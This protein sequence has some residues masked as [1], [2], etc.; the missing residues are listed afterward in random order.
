ME[1]REPTTEEKEDGGAPKLLLGKTGKIYGGPSDVEER[2][3]IEEKSSDP[4]VE[5]IH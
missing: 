1:E 3:P 5:T 4:D 2:D